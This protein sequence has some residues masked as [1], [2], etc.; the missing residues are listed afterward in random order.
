MKPLKIEGY[1][2]ILIGSDVVVGK[3]S[4]LAA[5][6]LTGSKCTLEIKSGARIGNFNHIY[7]TSKIIIEKDVLTADKVYISDNQHTY[8]SIDMPIHK[9]RIKQLK[10]VSIGEGTWIGEN[11]CIIGASIGKNCVIG[12]NSI[13]NKDIPDFC[14]AVGNPVKIVKRYCVNNKAWL[15]TNSIGEF[16]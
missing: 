7:A 3:Y 8:D 1:K 5:V 16:N 11:V 9:Q 6:P 15:K 4:W 12:A 2:N 13:V 14:V 10:H